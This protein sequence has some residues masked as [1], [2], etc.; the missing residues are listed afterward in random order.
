MNR[1]YERVN[2]MKIPHTVEARRL[3]DV[4]ACYS[5]PSKAMEE[6]G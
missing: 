4:A 2:C 3:G 6:L 5:D 1:A